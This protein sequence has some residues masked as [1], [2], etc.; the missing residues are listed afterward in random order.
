MELF[1]M[2][3]VQVQECTSINGHVEKYRQCPS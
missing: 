3:E 2:L 1:S